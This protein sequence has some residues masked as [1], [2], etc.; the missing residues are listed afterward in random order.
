VRTPVLVVGGDRDTIFNRREVEATA[1]AY[2]TRATFFPTAHDMM[3]EDDWPA[4]A[5]HILRWLRSG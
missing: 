5:D 3:L 2:R 4:V 1:R